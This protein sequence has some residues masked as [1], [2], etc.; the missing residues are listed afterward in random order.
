MIYV[1]G[2]DSNVVE[3][4]CRAIG[5][6]GHDFERIEDDALVPGAVFE[7]LHHSRGTLV[8]VDTLARIAVEPVWRDVRLFIDSAAASGCRKLVFVSSRAPTDPCVVALR[9]SGVPYTV[10]HVSRLLDIE[11]DAAAQL[12]TSRK[13]IVPKQLVAETAGSVLIADIASAVLEVL[14]GKSDGRTLTVSCAAGEGSLLSLLNQLGAKTSL[15]G[16]RTMWWRMLGRRQLHIDAHGVLRLDQPTTTQP[17]DE[18]AQ[19]LAS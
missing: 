5:A 18:T 6:A 4:L 9:R 13:V 8:L 19:A 11:A 2:E 10:L 7:R 15:G 1:A 16:M 3:A 14:S 12:L 17:P